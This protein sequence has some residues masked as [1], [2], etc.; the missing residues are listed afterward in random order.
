MVVAILLQIKPPTS[1]KFSV[2]ECTDGGL[3]TQRSG[4]DSQKLQD[5]SKFHVSVRHRKRVVWSIFNEYFPHHC[6]QCSL[7][8]TTSVRVGIIRYPRSVLSKEVF[9]FIDT[10]L[11]ITVQSAG[12]LQEE[13]YIC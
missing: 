9:A 3:Q 6:S 5:T 12:T 10:A 8:N 2:A 7:P 11:L 1:S 13:D 4:I